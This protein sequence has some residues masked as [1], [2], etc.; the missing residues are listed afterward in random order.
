M[1]TAKKCPCGTAGCNVWF[2]E[3]V[4]QGVSN[5]NE[6]Q[7]RAVADF[8]NSR[9]GTCNRDIPNSMPRPRTCAVC[10]LGPCQRYVTPARG[11]GRTTALMQGAPINALFVWCNEDL[12]Y[13]RSLARIL[14]RTDLMI[15]GPSIFDN[16]RFQELRG[17]KYSRVVLDHA[18]ELGP[19]RH[20]NWGLAISGARP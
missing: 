17:K 3:S 11:Q 2:V 13:P 16:D 20:A 8:L 15:F 14:H 4:V 10:K 7:A 18:T 1:F 9:P 5:F 19:Y 6:E 12:T